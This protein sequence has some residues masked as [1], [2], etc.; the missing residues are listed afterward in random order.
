MKFVYPLARISDYI[1][2]ELEQVVSRKLQWL[3]GQIT[4]MLKVRGSNLVLFDLFF[5]DGATVLLKFENKTKRVSAFPKSENIKSASEKSEN[6]QEGKSG[7]FQWEVRKL[8]M[9]GWE[10]SNNA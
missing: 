1:K 4:D 2:Y 9:E 10:L 6:L 7:Q 3:S 5:I 8:S